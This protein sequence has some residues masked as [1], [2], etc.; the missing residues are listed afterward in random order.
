[1]I[2][3]FA[4]IRESEYRKPK[5]TGMESVD[6]LLESELESDFFIRKRNQDVPGIM[7]H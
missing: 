1:M 5:G 7:H 6:F 4:G 3:F 2:P